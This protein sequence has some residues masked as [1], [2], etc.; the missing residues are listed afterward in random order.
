[1]RFPSKFALSFVLV[2]TSVRARGTSIVV[3]RTPEHIV[4]AADS[5]WLH[6]KG[7]ATLPPYKDCKMKRVGHIYF[8]AAT[9]DTDAR[10]VHSIAWQ[11]MSNAKTIADAAHSFSL[12][13]GELAARTAAHAGQELID[14]CWGKSCTEALFF[15]IE[16]GVPKLVLV[17]LEQVGKSRESLRFISHEFSCPGS[18]PAQPQVILCL[19]QQ[20]EIAKF[21]N[22]HPDFLQRNSDQSAVKKLVEIEKDGVPQ[23]VGGAIDVLTLDETGAHWETNKD[24]KC[25]P[26]ETKPKATAK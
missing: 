2:L 12:K 13:S 3:I 14:T 16:S 10:Q 21:K 20:E 9:V 5:L 23:W 24:G 8:T 19:G 11:A 22:A 7:N 1:M 15:G 17:K 18:C 26:E 25:W 4:V 6:T